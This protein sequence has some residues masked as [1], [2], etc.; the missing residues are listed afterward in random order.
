MDPITVGTDF[1]M[2][3]AV[4]KLNIRSFKEQLYIA[5]LHTQRYVKSIE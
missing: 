4:E 2:S 5:T 3:H 1:S